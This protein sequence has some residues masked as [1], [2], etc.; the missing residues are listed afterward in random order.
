MK[1]SSPSG[2]TPFL[3]K[4]FVGS[5][6][7]A[8]IMQFV[9]LSYFVA[10]QYPYNKNFSGYLQWF[11]GLASVLIVV[12]AVYFSRTKRTVSLQSLYEVALLSTILVLLSSVISMM[13][14]VVPIE[15]VT[16]ADSYVLVFTL[17]YQVLPLLLVLTIAF[18]ATRYLRSKKQW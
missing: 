6:A 12:G 7:F 2:V 5:A 17:L 9:Q 18:L 15:L 4:V 1:A 3:K 13:I 14:F 16:N 11:A 10:Q 8:L